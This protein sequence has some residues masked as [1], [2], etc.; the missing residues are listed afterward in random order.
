VDWNYKFPNG[1]TLWE[2]LCRQ[3]HQGANEVTLL[4]DQWK[5]MAASIDEGRF[6]QVL[7]HLN[8]QEQE[9]KWWRD[10]CLS[11]FMTFSKMEIPSDLEPPEHDLE[12]Y[13]SLKYPVAPGI[14]PRW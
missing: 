2:S 3:Y 8:I 11:Y 1:M 10:A 5:G 12:Y 14:R 4:K 7:M 13:M 6:E 9:A